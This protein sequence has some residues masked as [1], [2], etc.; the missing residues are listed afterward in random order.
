[1]V[2]LSDTPNRAWNAAWEKA[3]PTAL[4]GTELDA[5]E[6]EYKQEEQRIE[7]WSAEDAAER[8][9]AQLDDVLDQTN[10]RCAEIV[11][12]GKKWRAERVA[13]ADDD[14]A[15]AARLQERLDSI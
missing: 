10:K 3:W 9:I 7:I 13:A 14:R 6:W 12:Q 4:R 2:L 15:E 8:L 11:D 1:M 5:A